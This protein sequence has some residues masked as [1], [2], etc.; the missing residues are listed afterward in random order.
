MNTVGIETV[1]KVM[2]LNFNLMLTRS[3]TL[4]DRVMLADGCGGLVVIDP[5]Q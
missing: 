5:V 4:N 1:A 3:H 2:I